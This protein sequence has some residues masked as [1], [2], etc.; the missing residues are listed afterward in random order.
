MKFSKTNIF[1]IF[2]AVSTYSQSD[3]N[4]PYSIFGIGKEH[5][6]S[7]GNSN[8]LGYT[9][10]AYKSSQVLNLQNPAA[11]AGLQRGT[12]IYEI[13]VSNSFSSKRD[14]NFSQNNN[15]FN[16]TSFGIGFSA[17]NNWKMS[18]G[19]IPE[20]KVSYEVDYVQPVEGS[21]SNSLSNI[22]G[23]GGVNE[24]YW[25]NAYQLYDKFSVGLQLIAYFGSISQT[26]L[27][28]FTTSTVE[29]EENNNYNGV[30]LKAG[31]QFELPQ[32]FNVNT[33]IGATVS[34]PSTLNGT[35]DFVSNKTYSSGGTYEM[36]SEE[37]VDTDS[38]EIPLKIGVGV[39]SRIKDFTI[40]LD[41]KKSYWED[42]Y[43]SNDGFKY[44]NQ[45]FYGLG[46]EY[47]TSSNDYKY[48][49]KV[50]YRIGANYDSGYLKI[51]NNTIDSYSFSAGVGLPISKGNFS[52]LN[53]TYSYS[54]EG[55]LNNNLIIDNIHK[56]SLNLSL[57]GRWFQRKKIF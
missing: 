12:F 31:F 46:V 39:S 20:T 18:F 4:S 45:N 3:F 47:K 36:T 21:I 40:N 9:G 26:E 38:F 29:I 5:N 6:S 14:D 57:N 30:G 56:L 11:L 24:V 55:T 44:Y 17:S 7:F 23:S 19:L 34:L 28:S 10:I 13:G 43:Q 48:W 49:N 51:S 35:Q 50:A 8:A 25:A 1:L 2:V 16:F 53:L 27:L 33:S 22:T 42:S 41:Y 54:K 52:M 32:I 15:D 37:D